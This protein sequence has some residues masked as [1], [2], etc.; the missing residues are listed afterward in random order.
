M[1]MPDETVPDLLRRFVPTPHHLDLLFMGLPLSVQTNDLDLLDQMQ[2]ASQ[3]RDSEV[4]PALLLKVIRDH[5][6]VNDSTDRTLISAG[7]LVTMTIGGCSVLMLDCERREILG[8]LSACVTSDIF[9]SEFLPSLLAR[10]PKGVDWC[11]VGPTTG[12]SQKSDNS[13]I[14]P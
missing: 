8:F 4:P 13:E 7:P 14:A 3:A 6:V 10:I 1:M 11:V 12:F 9:I 5:D 2:S